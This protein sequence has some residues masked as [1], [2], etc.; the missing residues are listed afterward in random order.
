MAGFVPKEDAVSGA[1]VRLSGDDEIF[2]HKDFINDVTVRGSLNVSGDMRVSQIVDFTSESGD[3]SGHIFRGDTAY[4][5]E[6]VVGQLSASE[7]TGG[8]SGETSGGLDLS[9]IHI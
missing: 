1:Y 2:G 5:D 9:L 8:S 7:T 3:I 6:I 4:F